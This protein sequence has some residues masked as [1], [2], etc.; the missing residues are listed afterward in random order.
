MGLCIRRVSHQCSYLGYQCGI[1]PSLATTVGV[2]IQ[3]EADK[4]VW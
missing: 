4:V 3:L 1:F 2:Y